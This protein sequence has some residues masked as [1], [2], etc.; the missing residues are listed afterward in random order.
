MSIDETTSDR[1]KF[2]FLGI[3]DSDGVTKPFSSEEENYFIEQFEQEA[4]NSRKELKNN[5]GI[6]SHKHDDLD[7]WINKII[8]DQTLSQLDQYRNEFAHRLDS[9]ENLKR[10]LQIRPPQS[11]EKMLDIL[12]IVL[13]KYNECF[14][15]IL[16]Y[17][18]SQHYLGVRGLKY[19]SL[20]RLK[21]ADSMIKRKKLNNENS[22]DIN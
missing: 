7:E 10:E 22:S 1:N 18:K 6:T 17:T 3:I 11:I 14:Q 2:T 5:S 9:L 21:L 15:S 4:Y 20:S 13:A 16:S 8:D 12:S 19:D